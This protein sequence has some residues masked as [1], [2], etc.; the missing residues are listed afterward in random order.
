MFPIQTD[1]VPG[2]C[3]YGFEQTDLVPGVCNYG[4]E[5]TDLVPGVCN[6]GFEQ[7]DLV[8]GVCNYGFEQTDLV[9]GVCIYGFEQIHSCILLPPN[10]FVHPLS[11]SKKTAEF[12][13]SMMGLRPRQGNLRLVFRLFSLMRGLPT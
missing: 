3:N 1:L 11:N 6:Y 12:N 13:K 4:F 10:L 5:Q 8:P 7:T 9:P 2:V